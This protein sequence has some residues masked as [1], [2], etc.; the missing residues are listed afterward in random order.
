MAA[1]LKAS[2]A[3]ER[4]KIDYIPPAIEAASYPV[5][6]PDFENHAREYIEEN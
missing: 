6:F 1:I 5:D 2:G 4:T 3:A